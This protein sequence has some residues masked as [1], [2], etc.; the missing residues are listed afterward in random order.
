MSDGSSARADRGRYFNRE[1][2]WLQFD[3]RVLHEAV[4]ERHPL[5][6]RVKFVAISDTNLD[7]FMMVRVSG[8]LEQVRAGVTE[9]SPDGLTPEE[10]LALIR[11]AIL[12]LMQAQRA[13]LRDILLPALEAEQI[14]LTTLDQL[15]PA[16]RADLDRYFDQE[17]FPVC[18]PLGFDPGHPFPFISNLSVSL[19]VVL[20]DP[21]G[22]RRFARV[23]IPTVLP[24]LIQAPGERETTFIWLDD[25]IIANLNKLFPGMTIREV[26]TFRVIRDADIQI[27]DLE[28]GDLL[29]SV[30]AGLERRRF[31]SVVALQI[32]PSLPDYLRTLLI[33][34]LPVDPADIYVVDGP[35]GLGALMELT[36]INRPDLKDPPF[37]PR[38]PALLRESDIFSVIRDHDV[39]LHHPF[40]SFDPVIEL[41]N[42]AAVDPAV[43]AVKQT[44]Y[45]VGAHSPVVE[46]LLRAADHGKQVAVLV[47][48]KA[49]FDEENNIE[50][51]R[52]LERA[53]VHVTYGLVGLKTHCKLLLIV[54]RDREGLRRY[55]HIGTGNYNPSTARLY[56]DLGLLTCRPEI[57]ADVSELFNFLTGYS[58]QT[59]YRKLLVAPYTIRHGILDRIE[60]EIAAHRRFGNGRIIMKMNQLVDPPCVDALTRAAEAGVAID[61]L[62]RGINVL[63][64]DRPEVARHLRVQSVLGRF[65]E[66]SRIYYFHNGGEEEI[67]IG[68][69]DLM[70]RNLDHRVEVLVPIEDPELRR[71]IRDDIL[72]RYLR[73]EAGSYFLEPE[74]YYRPP[75]GGFDAQ[76]DLLRLAAL[77]EATVTP[78]TGSLSQPQRDD[79][80]L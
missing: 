16:T 69:A 80:D 41:L 18:T 51:A 58:R 75:T 7:E 31:G 42:Q 78:L 56:T 67:L 1:L 71:L 17:V 37:H 46:A 32:N 54:R 74:G 45:R 12:S 76:A 49:R 66:H 79:L 73:D 33:E 28:A 26:H 57:A 10:Q 52:A 15:S 2:S 72:A 59:R 6:E 22:T 5:L 20:E 34:K 29:E 9:R 77:E 53:G 43:L 50:W 44:L 4:R 39:L 19:A 62:V 40:D 14:R 36:R 47:E 25:L 64:R 63:R 8:L 38:V 61:L 13:C 24:R 23:K 21:E 70:P 35:L 60:R 68:S 65:L 30:Q 55:V 11:P 27:Q 48:L 3:E